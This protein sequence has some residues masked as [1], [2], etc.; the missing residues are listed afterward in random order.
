VPYK[1]GYN[2]D[3]SGEID[4]GMWELPRQHCLDKCGLT[5]GKGRDTGAR[6]GG[7]ESCIRRERGKG[8]SVERVI[9]GH[10]YIVQAKPRLELPRGAACCHIM[11]SFVCD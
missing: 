1:G 7:G 3:K 11:R 4:E 8:G 9:E 6:E 5:G 10:A 2:G